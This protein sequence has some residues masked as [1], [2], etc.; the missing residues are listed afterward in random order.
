VTWL[1][2]GAI[3]AAWFGLAALL[4]WFFSCWVRWLRGDF[5]NPPPPH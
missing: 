5:D 1:L 4:A 3:V 2:V